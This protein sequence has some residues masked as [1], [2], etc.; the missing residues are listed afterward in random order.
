MRGHKR[1]ILLFFVMLTVVA[2]TSLATSR[3]QDHNQSSRDEQ[4]KIDKKE[5]ESQFPIA[6]YATPEPADPEKRA[7]RQAKGK[8]YNVAPVPVDEHSVTIFST[9][10]W[11]TGLPS[12]PVTKSH[13]IVIGSVIDAQ[14]YLSDDKTGVYSEFTIEI[15]EILKNDSRTPLIPGSSIVAERS[16]GRVRFP[17]GHITLSHTRGQGMP[18][19]G[20]RY[21]LFLTHDFPLVGFQEQDF[22]ILTG[23]EL[24]AGRVGLLD[25]PS[26]H[27]IT[28]QNGKDEASFLNQLRTTIA[29]PQSSQD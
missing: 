3:G 12:L 1:T 2:I 25:N 16:G 29:A 7:K 17:S 18:R 6:H 23:Y 13:A 20:R 11:D 5:F 24:K 19:V 14:A 9:L 4:Q 15:D 27:P 26:Q 8:K 22:Y 10:D 28:E 21:V